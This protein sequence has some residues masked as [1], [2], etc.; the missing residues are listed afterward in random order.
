M[1][2]DFA[3]QIHALSGFNADGT[4]NT[5]TEDAFNESAAQWMTNGAKEVINILSKNSDVTGIV[6]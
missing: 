6:V 1:A 3:A 2:W 5:E 4:D